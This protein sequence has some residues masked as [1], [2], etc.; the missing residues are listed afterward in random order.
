M[1][2]TQL[3]PAEII[4]YITLDALLEGYP[5][6]PLLDIECLLP[7]PKESTIITEGDITTIK[8]DEVVADKGY[9]IIDDL[10]SRL[11][12]ELD[13]S[14]TC[15]VVE[16]VQNID[17]H[18]CGKANIRF[19]ATDY[20]DKII[21]LL[22]FNSEKGFDGNEIAEYIKSLEELAKL[23]TKTTQ[24]RKPLAEYYMADPT[25]HFGTYYL[26]LRDR[27]ERI[28]IADIEGKPYLFFEYNLEKA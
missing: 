17:K 16:Q 19:Y 23:A 9:D 4:P 24:S 5:K 2:Q 27:I 3:K 7:Q 25:F 22:Q 6:S 15:Y 14:L 18:C 21:G 12:M 20:K 13:E 26:L 8:C 28:G 10:Q 11:G 1:L